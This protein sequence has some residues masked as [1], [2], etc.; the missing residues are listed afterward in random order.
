MAILKPNSAPVTLLA[1]TQ[2]LDVDRH[3]APFEVRV[4]IAWVHALM[5]QN[6][7]TQA[8][9]TQ[10]ETLLQEALRQMQ[11]QTF[12]WKIEDED[13]HMN[14]ERFLTENA[15]SLGKKIH[16]GRSRNDLIATTLRLWLHAS[17]KDVQTRV[18]TVMEA[19]LALA[20]KNIDV[21]IPGLTHVQHGQPLRLAQL[22]L[23]HAHAF[24]RDLTRLHQAKQSC[25][26][27][28]P[29]G[30]AAFAGTHL[31]LDFVTLAQELDFREP[32]QNGYDAVGD[33]DFLLETLHA[34]ALIA[35]HLARL[36][37]EFLF[38]SA[39][40]VGL[41]ILPKDYSTGSSIMPNKR[42]PDVLE[43]IRAKTARILAAANEGTQIV[44]CVIPSYGSDLHELKRTFQ[45][46]HVELCA[47][48]EILEPFLL[49]LAVSPERAQALLET[50][51]ILATDMANQLVQDGMPF[52]D[53]YQKMAELVAAADAKGKPVHKLAAS[54][55]FHDAVEKRAA[56]GGSA[57]S[58]ILVQMESLKRKMYEDN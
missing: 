12:E 41:F 57:K 43:L 47:C 22:F 10:A 19:L 5:R 51:H 37:E 32:C 44:K 29:L 15:G 23:A 39:T 21:L 50:G 4:Q 42:N 24:R 33:R 25:L 7:L 26:E 18:L 34:Y 16:Y 11:T 9:A 3:L 46:A 38:Y 48:L 30:A 56:P 52:R 1:F 28:L 49:G 2:G 14:L 45:R 55:D 31:D 54:V 20:Q 13:I 6:L 27:A 53:A 36:C 8:E 58:Q 17:A 35:T 40:A